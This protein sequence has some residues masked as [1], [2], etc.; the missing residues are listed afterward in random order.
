MIASRS[1]KSSDDDGFDFVQRMILDVG[2]MSGEQQ[3]SIDKISEMENQIV[4]LRSDLRGEQAYTADLKIRLE[5]A[6]HG[7]SVPRAVG[8]DLCPGDRV[9]IFT[10]YNADNKIGAVKLWREVF[11]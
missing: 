2:S 10:G 5:N 7:L 9:V 11:G 3:R 6:E 4:C 1:F 8:P